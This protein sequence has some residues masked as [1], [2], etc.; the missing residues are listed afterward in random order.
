[1]IGLDEDPHKRYR[2]RR[3]SAYKRFDRKH[4][5]LRVAQIAGTPQ[6]APPDCSSRPS[7]ST[8]RRWRRTAEGKPSNISEARSMINSTIIFGKAH[9]KGDVKVPDGATV[10]SSP[11]NPPALRSLDAHRAGLQRLGER[12]LVACVDGALRRIGGNGFLDPAH[13]GASRW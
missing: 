3:E 2:P 8:V 1:M 6:L 10:E 13:D 4:V 5:A 7:T 12:R 11:Q 9:P